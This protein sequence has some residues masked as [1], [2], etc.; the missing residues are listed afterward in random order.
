MNARAL[1]RGKKIRSYGLVQGLEHLQL[2]RGAGVEK[3]I[4]I[5]QQ[6]PFIEY[7]EPD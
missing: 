6:L 3:A 7:A 5:L 1:V 2:G 4:E